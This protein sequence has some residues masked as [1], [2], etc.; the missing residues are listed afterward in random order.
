MDWEGRLPLSSNRAGPFVSALTQVVLQLG[1]RPIALQSSQ[2]EGDDAVANGKRKSEF[3]DA[4]E[5]KRMRPGSGN[6]SKK[7]KAKGGKPRA[8]VT[9]K[10]LVDFGVILPGRNRISVQYK[11]INYLANLGKD[12]VIMYQGKKFGSATAF[13][14]HCKRMQT[15]NKQ[16]DDGWKSTLYDGQPL[17]NYRRKY[18]QESGLDGE[19]EVLK[20]RMQLQFCFPDMHGI[21]FTFNMLCTWPEH[22]LFA[23]CA[24]KWVCSIGHLSMQHCL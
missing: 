24:Q 8:S 5:T 4:E 10:E 9:L 20:Q 15:P 11:G 18:F 3:G 7:G 2:Y 22:S 6:N 23:S 14:I 17:E 16:G 21:A 1:Q 19:A 12:G 13:S